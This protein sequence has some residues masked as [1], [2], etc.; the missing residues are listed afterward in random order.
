MES[1]PGDY[2]YLPD[3]NRAVAVDVRG[4]VEALESVYEMDALVAELRSGQAP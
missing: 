4:I 2:I 3:L 1:L